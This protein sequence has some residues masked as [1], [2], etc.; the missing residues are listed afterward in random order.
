MDRPIPEENELSLEAL[1]L[2]SLCKAFNALPR[3]GGI[4]DQD[5]L[6]AYVANIYQQAVA[7]REAEQ[8]RKTEQQSRSVASQRRG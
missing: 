7:E 4:L 2:V 8:V 3:A 5:S 1:G 6:F